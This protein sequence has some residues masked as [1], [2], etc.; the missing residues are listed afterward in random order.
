M[1]GKSVHKQAKFINKKKLNNG[2]WRSTLY[3]IQISY[4][5]MNGAYAVVSNMHKQYLNNVSSLTRLI[6][7]C[8][9]T[10]KN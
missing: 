8:Y 9:N 10:M 2:I 7:F 3:I 5:T 4:W 6:F 1:V